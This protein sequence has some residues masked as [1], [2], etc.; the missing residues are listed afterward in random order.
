MS[1]YYNY[2]DP[3]LLDKLDELEKLTISGTYNDTYKQVL[4]K[5]YITIDMEGNNQFEHLHELQE[6][7]KQRLQ[8]IK[9][10]EQTDYSNSPMMHTDNL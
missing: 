9:D 10:G 6:L 3:E 2:I 8:T 4:E 1:V 7:L 5:K